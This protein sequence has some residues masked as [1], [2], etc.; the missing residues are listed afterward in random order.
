MCL[1]FYQRSVF[2]VNVPNGAQTA[3]KERRACVAVCVTS[4]DVIL[5]LLVTWRGNDITIF[6]RVENRQPP[7]RSRAYGR[8]RK[9]KEIFLFGRM[10]DLALEMY[11][12][13]GQCE[14]MRPTN[15]RRN[16][17]HRPTIFEMLPYLAS[18]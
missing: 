8:S 4:H 13:T 3:E 16:I 2:I 14:A 10:S 15:A 11:I 5:L 6:G 17:S 18:F 7:P 9:Q 12:F 1:P